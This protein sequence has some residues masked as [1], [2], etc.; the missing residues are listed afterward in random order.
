MHKFVHGWGPVVQLVH[1]D[2]GELDQAGWGKSP[3]AVGRPAPPSDE[4]LVEL[5]VK[6]LVSGTI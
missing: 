4:L 2:Q 6:L 3:W 1:P 5:L